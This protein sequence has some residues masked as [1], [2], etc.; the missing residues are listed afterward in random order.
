M[1]SVLA[2]KRRRVAPGM[3]LKTLYTC[4]LAHS[5]S[6]WLGNANVASYVLVRDVEAFQLRAGG[7]RDPWTF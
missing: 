3:K 6:V 7:P 5:V 1:V 4:A 2:R